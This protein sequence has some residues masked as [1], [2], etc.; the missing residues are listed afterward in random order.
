MSVESAVSSCGSLTSTT[1]APAVVERALASADASSHP[2]IPTL[3]AQSQVG[4]TRIARTDTFKGGSTCSVDASHTSSRQGQTSG[5]S[6][7]NSKSVSRSATVRYR[8]CIIPPSPHDTAMMD[9]RLA[10]QEEPVDV[11]TIAR[12]V[13]S[14]P[15]HY[16]VD[17]CSRAACDGATPEQLNADGSPRVGSQE[18]PTRTVDGILA[19]SK[20]DMRAKWDA[21]PLPP[22]SS[23]NAILWTLRGVCLTLHQAW[24]SYEVCVGRHARQFHAGVAQAPTPVSSGSRNSPISPTREESLVFSLGLYT[25][26]DSWTRETAG[27]TSTPAGDGSP[28]TASPDSHVTGN[29]QDHDASEWQDLVKRLSGAGQASILPPSQRAATATVETTVVVN[30]QDPIRSYVRQSYSNGSLCTLESDWLNVGSQRDDSGFTGQLVGMDRIVPW[31]SLFSQRL[32]FSGLSSSI[33][34]AREILRVVGR[35]GDRGVTI[36]GAQFRRRFDIAG[37]EPVTEVCQ[38]AINTLTRLMKRANQNAMTAATNIAKLTS[39]ATPPDRNGR[40]AAA[41]ESHQAGPSHGSAEVERPEKDSVARVSAASGEAHSSGGFG[42]G[43]Q[44]ARRSAEVRF[45]CPLAGGSMANQLATASAAAG[46]RGR[47]GDLSR[48][49]SGAPVVVDVDDI[50]R[51]SGDD[52]QPVRRARSA[53]LPFADSKPVR[54]QTQLVSVDE[55]SLCHYQ[56]TVEVPELCLHPAFAERREADVKPREGASTASAGG[57]TSKDPGQRNRELDVISTHAEP[58][59]HGTHAARAVCEPLNVDD[60]DDGDDSCSCASD[61]MTAIGA[62]HGPCGDVCTSVTSQR[63]GPVGMRALPNGWEPPLEMGA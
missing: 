17:V 60:G 58:I 15:C 57:S 21:E 9:N 27:G 12:V 42:I 48:H 30:H 54:R 59:M 3:S 22:L 33:F 25:P 11:P 34:A 1:M 56:L 53:S 5:P 26:V 43:R 2:T 50:T 32:L 31:L 19:S 49:D 6:G 61:R 28:T 41:T 62:G 14:P 37:D 20:D 38:P 55:V 4:R 51:Q 10:S 39:S 8:C 47:H 52:H 36:F 24:W 63:V 35:A 46:K 16:L 23:V 29:G 18:S 40:P 45:V 13:E 7:R 44:P